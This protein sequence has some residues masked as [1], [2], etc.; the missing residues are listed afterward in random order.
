M[1]GIYA[2]TKQAMAT[3]TFDWSS[4]TFKIMLVGPGYTPNY[5]ADATL[6]D[7]PGGSKLLV[8]ALA[9]TGLTATNG[10]CMAASVHW[11]SLTTTAPV[12]GIALVE[13]NGGA[14]S[15]WQLVCYVDEGDG[16]GNQPSSQVVNLVFD[17]RG[18][19]RP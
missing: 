9:L 12:L 15:T 5:E 6:A 4:G 1:S 16:F 2:I 10:F 17:T 8:N 11:D 13:A 14:E 19:L 7:I 18:I 3:G